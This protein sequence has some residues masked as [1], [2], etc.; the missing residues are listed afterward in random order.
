M[1][2]QTSITR[3]ELQNLVHQI[4]ASTLTG[5]IFARMETYKAAEPHKDYA[6]DEHAHPLLAQVTKEVMHMYTSIWEA[7]EAIIDNTINNTTPS[8]EDTETD[9]SISG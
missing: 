1:E 5:V 7:L 9:T 4:V 8:P 2:T 3:E 6:R